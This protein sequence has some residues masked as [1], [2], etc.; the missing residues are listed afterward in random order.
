MI[1]DIVTPNAA[2]MTMSEPIEGEALPRSTRLSIDG[3]SPVASANAC[4]VIDRAWRAPLIR[5]PIA[6]IADAV[7]SVIS[8]G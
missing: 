3:L 1:A 5:T 2:E 6:A 4:S 8:L 7:A